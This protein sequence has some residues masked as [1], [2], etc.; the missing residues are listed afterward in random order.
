[1]KRYSIDILCLCVTRWEGK[2]EFISDDCRVIWSGGEKSGYNGVV[3]VLNQ[4]L[5]NK[6]VNSIN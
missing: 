6:V 3:L 2:E 4:K 5:G 1:M